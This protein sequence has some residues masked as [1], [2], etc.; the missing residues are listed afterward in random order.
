MVDRVGSGTASRAGEVEQRERSSG[1]PTAVPPPPPA[2]APP[3]GW[4]AGRITALVIGAILVLVSVGLLGAG[5]TAMWVDRTQRDAAG[6]VATG[7]HEYS[8]G[9]SALVTEPAELDSP[10]V[11]W[12]YSSVVLGKV[13][14]RVTPVNS[15]S[16]VFVGIGPSDQVD[17][18]LAGTSHALISDFWSDAVHAVSGGTPATPPGTQDFWVATATGPGAQSLT[19]DAANGSWSVVVMNADGRPGVD[20]GADLGATFPA[21]LGIAIG[22]LVLGGLC[23]LGGTLLIAGAIRRRSAGRVVTV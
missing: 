17:R 5:G 9:G 3:S 16:P 23:V 20:V 1:R 11:G 2:A 14:I 18:Y 4:T 22:S 15:G 7:V 10:G 6:Y 19:W 13:R 8:T 12:F 21:L